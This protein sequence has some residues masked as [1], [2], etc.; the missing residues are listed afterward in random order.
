MIKFY[1]KL[2]NKA[3]ESVGAKI[4]GIRYNCY[5]IFIGKGQFMNST[6]SELK[7]VKLPKYEYW[8]DPFIFKYKNKNYVFFENY[9]Y[10]T[11]KGKISCGLIKKGNLVKISD[12][13]DLDYHLSFPYIFEENGIIYLMPEASGNNRL[14]IFRC[15]EFPNKWELHSTAFE[16]EKVA[17][18][19]FFNDKNNDKWLFVNKKANIKNIQLDSELYIYR[20]DSLSLKKIEPHKQ[21]PV[22]INSALA[23]NG[24]SIFSYGNDIYRPSQANIRGD[25]GKA[26]NINKIEKLT[27]NHY[28]ERNIKTVYPN[29]NR[30]LKSMHHLHQ[31]DELF[32]FDATY[33]KL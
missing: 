4:F 13:L 5:T 27:L 14:E 28:I 12:V 23:R 24:G 8:A 22:I 25:Y 33:K 6:L 29:F 17:D 21:N 32:V 10:I 3:I 18:A 9:S 19:F 15:I 26:L 31:T 7:P 1:K 11:K 30:K 2:L 20:V 16:N